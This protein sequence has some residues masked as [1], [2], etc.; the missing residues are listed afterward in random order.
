V[1]E[2][3]EALKEGDGLKVFSPAM[4]VAHPLLALAGVIEIEHGGD[5]VNTKAVDVEFLQPEHGAGKQEA[6]DFV[7]PEVED[8]RAP[9]ELL[10]L[11]RVFVFVKTST[12]EEGQP[13]SVLREVC[14]Y[15]IE[16]HTYA[17]LMAGVDEKLE[18]VGITEARS[19]RKVACYL[20]APGAGEWMLHRWHQ[21]DVVCSRDPSHRRQVDLPVPDS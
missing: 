12:V 6:L 18:V 2:F 7:A 20:I 16:D 21:F 5:C 14:R 19:G 8:E 9:V 15:P 10:A 1:A 17:G 13:V 3:I 11:A 4:F